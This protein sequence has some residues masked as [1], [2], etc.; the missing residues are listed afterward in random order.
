MIYI[1][2]I[3]GFVAGFIVG[4]SLLNHLL[5]DVPKEELTNDPYIK[6]KY[7]LMCW[8]MAAFGSYFCVSLYSK[9]FI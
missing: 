6:W 5:H 9:L 4:L 7:G 1:I 3:F 8:G 2:G